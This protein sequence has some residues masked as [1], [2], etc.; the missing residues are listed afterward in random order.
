MGIVEHRGVEIMRQRPRGFWL[1]RVRPHTVSGIND[2]E[3]PAGEWLPLPLTSR[4][5]ETDARDA[6]DY[7]LSP[8]SGK[9]NAPISEG[10]S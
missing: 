3:I 6:V 2:V 8:E 4:A 9:Q 7:F 10:A 5:T 1:A